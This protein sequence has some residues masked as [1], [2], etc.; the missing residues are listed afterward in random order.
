VLPVQR[1]PLIAIGAGVALLL[2]I[3]GIMLG[4]WLH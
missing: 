3:F 4:R 1:G 2:L